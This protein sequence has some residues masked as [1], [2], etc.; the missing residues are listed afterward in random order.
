MYYICIRNG[1]KEKKISKGP[2]K[3]ATEDTSTNDVT[4]KVPYA[5][6]DAAF[7]GDTST[8]P[9]YA[10]TDVASVK[11]KKKGKKVCTYIVLYIAY[12]CNHAIS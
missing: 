6:N 12:V 4:N 5:T 10:V 3:C 7:N 2:M 11:N 8:I 1:V 9:S